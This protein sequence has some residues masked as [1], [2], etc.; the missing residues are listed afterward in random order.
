MNEL[1]QLQNRAKIVLGVTIPL[2]IIA[3]IALFLYKPEYIFLAIIIIIY[4]F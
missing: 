1:R 2:A 4:I 3:G